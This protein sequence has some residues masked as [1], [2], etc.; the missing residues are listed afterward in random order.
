[1]SIY[2]FFTTTSGLVF[3]PISTTFGYSFNLSRFISSAS[4][5]LLKVTDLVHISI[6]LKYSS[7]FCT[8]SASVF[9]SILTVGCSAVFIFID[10]RHLALG[11]TG[12][13]FSVSREAIKSAKLAFTTSASSL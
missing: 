4:K 3:F 8:I 13:R 1:M 9:A 6:F 12:S 11:T 10:F 7:S 5:M 2:F